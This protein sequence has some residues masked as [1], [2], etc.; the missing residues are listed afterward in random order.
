MARALVW[1]QAPVL[2][3]A[4]VWAP[5]PVQAP[6]QVEREATEAMGVMEAKHQ[7]LGLVMEATPRALASAME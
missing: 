6:V 1:A 3:Q 7:E 4:Q 2:A 5:V